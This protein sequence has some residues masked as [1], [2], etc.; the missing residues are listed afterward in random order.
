[1]AL[2]MALGYISDG[3]GIA[4]SEGLGIGVVGNLVG[5]DEGTLDGIGLGAGL[6]LGIGIVGSLLG[7]GD[8]I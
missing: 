1:M 6:G 5:L 3:E 2:L 8:G 4:E 7:L